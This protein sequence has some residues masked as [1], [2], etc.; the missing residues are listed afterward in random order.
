MDGHDLE[1]L[2]EIF[3]IAK[4]MNRPVV[5]HAQTTKGKGYK[6]AEGSH[7]HWHGVSPF[8]VKTGKSLK[9]GGGEKNATTVFSE[10]LAELAELDE[11]VVGLTAAMPSGTGIGPLMEKYPD[12]FWDVAICEQ[13]AVTSSGGPTTRSS[14]TWPS[15]S[16]R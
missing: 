15:A 5:V 12:R 11:K 3:R 16:C 10:V 8:D 13:H 1:S 14:T 9:K 4:G 6:I 2:I 7:E